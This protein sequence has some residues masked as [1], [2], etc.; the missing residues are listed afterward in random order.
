VLVLALVL[1]ISAAGIFSA[2]TDAQTDDK[3]QQEEKAK[4][5]E[6][7]KK[8]Q[9]QKDEMKKKEGVKKTQMSADEKMKMSW[10]KI[11]ANENSAACYVAKTMKKKGPEAGVDAFYRMKQD[12]DGKW[13]FKEGEFNM[14]GYVFLHY[15][16]VDEAIAVFEL[17]VKE[18]P[19]SWNVY[20]S[21]GEAYMVAE[22]YD[23]SVKYYEKAL[24]M[25]PEAESA[26]KALATLKKKQEQQATS[27]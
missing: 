23:E 4:S 16:K 3:A 14:L 1:P 17:N 19:E 6:Q 20:D 18:H 13:V 5:D 26:R 12:E 8:E 15:K 2:R 21:L 24:A 9:M 10:E 22:R 7:L 25:N 27:L 11:C